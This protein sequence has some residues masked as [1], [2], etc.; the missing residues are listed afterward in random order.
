MN[1]PHDGRPESPSWA[2]EL[3][4]VVSAMRDV[5]AMLLELNGRAALLTE[6]VDAIVHRIVDEHAADILDE[7]VPLDELRA[8]RDP[9]DAELE[10]ERL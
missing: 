8:E 4:A 1:P 2:D 6:A 3:A 5:R 10:R 7:L 9:V